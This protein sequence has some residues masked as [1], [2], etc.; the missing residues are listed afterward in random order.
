MVTPASA[1][2]HFAVLSRLA[3]PLTLLASVAAKIAWYARSGVGTGRHK[4][5]GI[6]V[7]SIIHR[8]FP[9]TTAAPLNPHPKRGLRGPDAFVLD[10]LEPAR[11]GHSAFIAPL[12]PWRSRHAGVAASPRARPVRRRRSRK[13]DIPPIIAA[14]LDGVS[15]SHKRVVNGTSMH[16]NG[17]TPRPFSI[18]G[19]RIYVAGLY[20]EWRSDNPEAILHSPETKL[21]DIRFRRDVDT[22]ARKAWQESFE[23]NFKAPCAPAATGAV[24]SRQPPAEF[25]PAR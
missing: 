3:L 25:H 5:S 8:Q 13:E 14:D 24:G 22:E 15:V 2:I 12:W 4:R 6:A 23:Q 7:M 18:L 20:M 1:M 11:S 21:L 16:L 17:I 9:S 19:I 10:P